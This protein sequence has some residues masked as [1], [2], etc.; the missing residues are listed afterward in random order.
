MGSSLVVATDLPLDALDV[1]LDAGTVGDAAPGRL[2]ESSLV[3]ATDLLLT[4]ALDVLLDAVSVGDA[5]PG[6]AMALITP[7]T[8]EGAVEIRD[9]LLDDLDGVRDALLDGLCC[10]GASWTTSDALDRDL[11]DDRDGA[12]DALL[13]GLCCTGASGTTSG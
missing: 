10:T 7:Y 3:A 8:E 5:A 4:D 11:P 1:L 12:I 6:T 9:A 13:D 2:G